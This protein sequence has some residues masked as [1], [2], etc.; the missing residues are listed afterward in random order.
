[1]KTKVGILQNNPFMKQLG[2]FT[3]EYLTALSDGTI[4]SIP[5]ITR[6]IWWTGSEEEFVF[7]MDECEKI[8]NT[9]ES[10]RPDY[11]KTKKSQFKV[12]NR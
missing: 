7:T 8:A 2:S 12:Q 1:M 10:V 3:G 5:D 11:F 4:L 9:I 6:E